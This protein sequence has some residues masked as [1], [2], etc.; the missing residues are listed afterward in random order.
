M[1]SNYNN[2]IQKK[3][4][5]TNEKYPSTLSRMQGKNLDSILFKLIKE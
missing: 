1:V 3:K 4:L 2:N 5:K